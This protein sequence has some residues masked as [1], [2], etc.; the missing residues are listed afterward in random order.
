M[1]DLAEGAGRCIGLAVLR[2]G[3]ADPPAPMQQHGPA[4]EAVRG[5]DRAFAIIAHVVLG[6]W[7]L[8]VLL[9]LLW[10]IFTSFKSSQEILTSPFG[11]PETLRLDNYARAW[12]EALARAGADGPVVVANSDDPLITWAVEHA[13]PHDPQCSG[14]FCRDQHPPPQLTDDPL[15]ALWHDPPLHTIPDGQRLLQPPQCVGSC[16]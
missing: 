13:A 1:A 8:L 9:P 4:R 12:R 6:I 3:E 16:R 7:A 14:S 5:A 10:M 15:H 2:L 11:L